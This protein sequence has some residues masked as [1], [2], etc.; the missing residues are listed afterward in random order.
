MKHKYREP[1]PLIGASKEDVFLPGEKQPEN[2]EITTSFKE[3]EYLDLETS[4]SFT[5]KETGYQETAWSSK[6]NE[7]EDNTSKL[8][9]PQSVEI[10][11]YEFPA[12][13]EYLQDGQRYE[14]PDDSLYLGQ[15]DYL[16]SVGYSEDANIILEEEAYSDPEGSIYDGREDSVYLGTTEFSDE[17]QNYE[18][19]ETG[20]SLEEEE[21]SME[22]MGMMCVE[23]LKQ[24]LKSWLQYH[25][26]EGTEE[27]H[28][29]EAEK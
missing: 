27:W 3:K 24:N 19:P 28:Q 15:E 10:T 21:K 23:L 6:E 14:E 16:E 1:P 17:E 7:K 4:E 29:M 2:P 22:G 13:I 9:S 20:M 8:T 26:R 12:T 25:N 11:E 18:D 5:D